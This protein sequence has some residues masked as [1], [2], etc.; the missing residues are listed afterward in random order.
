MWLPQNFL[1]SRQETRPFWRAALPSTSIELSGLQRGHT[2][3]YCSGKQ[4]KSLTRLTSSWQLKYRCGRWNTK[5]PELAAFNHHL[6]PHLRM[7]RVCSYTAAETLHTTPSSGHSPSLPTIPQIFYLS[8]QKCKIRSTSILASPAS[9]GRVCSWLQ[10]HRG[11]GTAGS[12]RGKEAKACKIKSLGQA[13]LA[14]NMLCIHSAYYGKQAFNFNKTAFRFW[15]ENWH[16]LLNFFCACITNELREE[17][18]L[19]I[20]LHKSDRIST[21][22]FCTILPDS[23][24]RNPVVDKII[25]QITLYSL[26]L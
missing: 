22:L 19:A 23:Q 16:I 21:L 3:N 4:S 11:C 12:A 26:I 25:L 14:S 13:K 2:R 15:I 9:T 8:L 6:F 20:S 10:R 1:S 7:T 18:T 5:K 17:S 24:L